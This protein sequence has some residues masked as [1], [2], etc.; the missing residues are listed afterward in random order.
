MNTAKLDAALQAAEEQGAEVYCAFYSN[1]DAPPALFL[2]V[3][4]GGLKGD[5]I[6]P[7]RIPELDTIMDKGDNA[8]TPPLV[9][10]DY[11]ET[12]YRIYIPRTWE[13]HYFRF[14]TWTDPEIYF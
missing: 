6:E 2:I 4:L 11:L 12:H 7:E 5:D 13:T 14:P 9:V 10:I 1:T 8:N 3:Y